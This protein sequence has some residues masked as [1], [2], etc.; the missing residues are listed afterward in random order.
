[1][2]EQ[3]SIHIFDSVGGR[4][5]MRKAVTVEDGKPVCR[6]HTE[7]A[8]AER[9]A[10]SRQRYAAYLQRVIAPYER[11]KALRAIN[12]KLLAALEAWIEHVDRFHHEHSYPGN[13]C[14]WC[15]SREAE[16]REAIREAKE[17]A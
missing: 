7:A 9:E 8:K 15:L 13:R 14:D 11:V 12:A 6:Q 2:S 5:C 16:A 10:K 4:Q 1:M 3:C 17:E